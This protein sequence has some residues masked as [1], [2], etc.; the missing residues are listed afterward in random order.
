MKRILIV[1]SEYGYWGEE[2][3]G[4]LD[5]F[6]AA[7]YKVDFATPHG[8]RPIPLPPSMD[9]DY[10]DPPLGK[11]VTSKEVAK[12]TRDL[13]ASSRYDKPI[14]ISKW[15]PERPYWSSPTL[16]RDMEAYYA[17][18][19]ALGGDLAKYDS[20]LLVGGS[21]PIVDIANNDRIHALILCLPQAGQADRRGVLRRDRAGLRPGP[22]RSQEHHL[23]QARHR[24]IA[25]S[26][27]T[28]TGPASWARTSTWVRRRTRSSTSCATPPARMA[29]TTGTS[30][31]RHRSS[32]TTRSSPVARPR[33][34]T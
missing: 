6:D 32:S 23:G 8:K 30:G 26:T 29:A 17:K 7:G 28:R 11:S 27:T 19:D 20:I 33:T 15:V 4:P 3:V 31:T 25:R 2:L 9:P 16:L 22:D 14:D 1:L 5:T 18:L 10:I 24:A 12:K 21:G 34:R 13:D